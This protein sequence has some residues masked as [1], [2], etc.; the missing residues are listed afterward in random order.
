MITTKQIQA[1]L[2]EEGYDPGA[3][4]G[5]MGPKTEAAILAFNIA[6]KFPAT[7]KLSPAALIALGFAGEPSTPWINEVNRY[8]GLHEV[9][10]NKTLRDWLRFGGSV[11]DPAKLPWCADLVETSIK[12]T[13]PNEPFI[14]KVGINPYY[15]LNWLEFGAQTEACYGAIAIFVRPGGGHIAFLIGYDPVRKRY[16]IRGGNQ[17]DSICDMWIEQSRCRGIR[18]PITYRGPKVPLPI[19]NSAGAVVSKNEA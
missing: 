7:I 10:N 12:L 14:G 15:S 3:L 13:M 1:A 17:G 4:D 8:M 11:G 2:A 16:R 5:L 19:L 18:W 9:R 6:N